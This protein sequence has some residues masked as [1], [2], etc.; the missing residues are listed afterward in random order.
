MRGIFD[1]TTPE[2]LVSKLYVEFEQF[3]NNPNDTYQAFN[4]FV[5]AEHIP[6][7]L[8]EKN[9]RKQEPLLRICSHIANGAKHFEVNRHNAVIGTEKER[10]AEEGYFAEDYAEEPLVIYLSE[11]EARAMGKES[12]RALE[13]AGM[14]V[15]YWAARLPNVTTE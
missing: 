15:D 1:L 3:Q 5:T 11:V 9:L 8:D 14:I 7:W 2:A 4:F 10:Y 12:I 6:D 13:L